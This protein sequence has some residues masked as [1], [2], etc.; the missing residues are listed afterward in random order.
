MQYLPD[1]VVQ[2][3][4]PS[5]DDIIAIAEDVVHALARGDIV[6]APRPTIETRQG[7]RFMAF[8]VILEEEGVAGVKWLG[9]RPTP[10]AGARGGSVVILSRSDS[11]EPIAIIDARWIT[12]IRTAVVSLLAA[13]VLA[14]KNARK[15]AFIACGEQAR[16]HLELFSKHFPLEQ[17]AAYSRSLETACQFANDVRGQFGCAAEACASPEECVRGADIVVS[18]TP[19]PSPT[20]LRADWLAEGSFCSLVD[21]GRS[22]DAATLPTGTLFVVDDPDQFKALSSSGTL[23]KFAATPRVSLNSVLSRNQPFDERGGFLMPTGLGAIDIRVAYEMY[24][25]A[26]QAGL[27]TIPGGR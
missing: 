22:L 1:T 18:S 23:N 17:V 19:S 20:L 5:V 4:K 13:K 10:S 6:T 3:L 16:L 26:L 7:V 11:A 12:A 9:I 8:P 2:R 15:L 21:L 14:A 25:K 24:R 27:G